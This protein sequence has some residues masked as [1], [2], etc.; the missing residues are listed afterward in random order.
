MTTKKILSIL[1]A[2]VMTLSLGA[3]AFAADDGYNWTPI[4]TSP[5]GL[6]DGEYYLD[7]TNLMTQLAQHDEDS[8]PD[9]DAMIAAYNGGTWF[10]DYD[11]VKLKGTIV[12]PAEFNDSGEDETVELTSEMATSLLTVYAGDILHEVGATW[13]PAAKS[14]EG[15]NDGDWYIDLTQTDNADLVSLLQQDDVAVYVNS[16]ADS[17]LMK[18]K[19]VVGVTTYYLPLT[20]SSVGSVFERCPLVQYTAPEQPVT[21]EESSEHSDS[22]DS[23]FSF[24][25][26]WAK[27]VAFFQKIINFFKNLFT[28]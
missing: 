23:G 15:L 7:F 16:N 5:E 9:L 2:L 11:S 27:I 21:P 6:A 22:S 8:V 20:E 13:I 1:L 25:S 17:R 26:L 14:A 3:V 12:V 10:F 19:F 18:I 28:R 4:P 24:S